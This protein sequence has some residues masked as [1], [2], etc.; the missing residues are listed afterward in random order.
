MLCKVK[1]LSPTSGFKTMASP[2]SVLPTWHQGHQAVIIDSKTQILDQQG[3]YIPVYLNIM[4]D[5]LG[6]VWFSGENG[7]THLFSLLLQSVFYLSHKY[8]FLAH[9]NW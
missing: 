8:H 7:T 3:R 2:L 1:F 6:S 5:F 4:L 9:S